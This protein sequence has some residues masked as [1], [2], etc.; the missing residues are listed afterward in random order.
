MHI[1][2]STAALRD[3][4]SIGDYIAQDNPQRAK[5]FMGEL[6]DQ[7]VK[8]AKSPQAYRLRSELGD[9]IRS[10]TYGNYVIFFREDQIM[11]R[12]L[13]ILHGSMDI[14]TRFGETQISTTSKKTS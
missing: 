6:R 7:C 8:I 9:G 3:L 14:E 2:L 12:V 11:L 13:R 10:C 5:S 4:E 1:E